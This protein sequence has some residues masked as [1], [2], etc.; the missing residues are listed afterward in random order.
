MHSGSVFVEFPALPSLSGGDSR[1]VRSGSELVSDSGGGKFSSTF[2][3]WLFYTLAR[4]SPLR[5]V[6]WI[7][8]VMVKHVSM[9]LSQTSVWN[10]KLMIL[11]LCP[12]LGRRGLAFDIVSIVFVS[13]DLYKSNDDV[14]R[15][16]NNANVANGQSV[17]DNPIISNS[18]SEF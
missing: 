12:Y 7:A 14:I 18:A 5:M 16:I 4:L 9:K 10:W 17:I 13:H 15:S 6:V 8:T 3:S 2:T 1:S 11:T